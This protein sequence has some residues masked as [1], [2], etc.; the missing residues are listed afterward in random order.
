M[1]VAAPAAI[2]PTLC[3]SRHLISAEACPVGISGLEDVCKQSGFLG[4]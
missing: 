4:A 2:R 3:V 1:S